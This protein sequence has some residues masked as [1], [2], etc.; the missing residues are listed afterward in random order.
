MEEIYMLIDSFATIL[1]GDAPI[2]MEE[3]YTIIADFADGCCE[4]ENVQDFAAMFHKGLQN[5]KE[6]KAQSPINKEGYDREVRRLN[7]L[8]QALISDT[9]NG[10]V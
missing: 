3:A 8:H 7:R 2:V 4:N 9:Q 6:I 10:L 1:F 5:I